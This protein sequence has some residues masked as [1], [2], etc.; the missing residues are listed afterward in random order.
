MPIFQLLPG[1]KPEIS[2]TAFFFV[3][4]SCSA[5][6]SASARVVRGFPLMR[7]A[8]MLRMRGQI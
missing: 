1:L 4:P 8:V 5:L 2:S 3:F 6:S 7:S